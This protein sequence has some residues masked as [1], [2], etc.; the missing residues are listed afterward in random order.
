MAGC[1]RAALYPWVDV[2]KME[3]IAAGVLQRAARLAATLG[4]CLDSFAHGM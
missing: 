4:A 2:L 1:I 3:A